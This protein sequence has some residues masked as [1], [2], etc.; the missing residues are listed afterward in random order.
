M[1]NEDSGISYLCNSE[2]PGL[3]KECLKTDEMHQRAGN[4]DKDLLR[5]VFILPKHGSESVNLD[6]IITGY[7]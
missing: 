2:Y 7:M 6:G 1:A 3:D 5:E 4:G